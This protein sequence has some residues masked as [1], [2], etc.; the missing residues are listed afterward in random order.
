MLQESH[1][2]QYQKKKVQLAQLVYKLVYLSLSAVVLLFSV[3][4]SLAADAEFSQC[5]EMFGNNQPPIFNNKNMTPKALCYSNFAILHSGASRTPIYVAER[6]NKELLE[7]KVSRATAFFAD[8]RIP[9][10]ERSELE[11][12]NGSGF[13]RGHMAPAGDMST[14]NSMQQSFSLAN[15]VPQDSVNNRKSW[16]SIEKATRKYVMRATGDV[17]VITGPIFEQN[18]LTIG[19]NKVWVPQ[20]LFKL[21]YDP[22]TGR[23][24]VHWLRNTSDSQVEKPISYTELVRRTGVEFLPGVSGIY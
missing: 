8:D 17:F 14:E 11:D 1:Y 7:V 3:T 4:V 13:D 18:H 6:L 15:I 24:W 5:K 9:P 20:Y 10:D 12:Y 21:V 2:K 16:A 23:A 22:I 19:M